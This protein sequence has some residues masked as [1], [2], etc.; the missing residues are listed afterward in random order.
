[1][2]RAARGEDVSI[3][4]PKHGT[5]RLASARPAEVINQAPEHDASIEKAPDGKA[6]PDS[7]AGS[8]FS[9]K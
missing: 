3:S 6:S 4:D 8:S 1:M 2:A 5:F 9:Y 7:Q